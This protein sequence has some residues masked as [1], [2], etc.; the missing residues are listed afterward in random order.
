MTFLATLVLLLLAAVLVTPPVVRHVAEDWL[1]EQ[2]VENA[3]VSKVSFNLF[4]GAVE[5]DTVNI[6]GGDDRNGALDVLSLDIDMLA[7]LSKHVEVSGVTMRGGEFDI[8]SIVEGGVHIG[9]L[10]FP[11]ANVAAGEVQE[12]QGPSAW[13]FGVY[14][15][16]I[17]DVTIRILDQ[18]HEAVIDIR[19]L[20]VDRLQSF[21]P[22][23]KTSVDAD[24]RVDGARLQ[25]DG[26]L[27][28]LSERPAGEFDLRVDELSLATYASLIPVLDEPEGALSLDLKV[29][30]SI[31][32]DPSTRLGL[33]VEGTTALSGFRA[34][35]TTLLATVDEVAWDGG[36]T[37]SIPGAESDAPLMAVTGDV[38]ADAIQVSQDD[39]TLLDVDSARISGFDVAGA[40]KALLPSVVIRGVS[41]L[42]TETA[43]SSLS[44]GGV[45]ILDVEYTGGEGLAVDRVEVSDTSL[46]VRRDPDGRIAGLPTTRESAPEDPAF[47]VSDDGVSGFAASLDT[48]SFTGNTKV[49]F[50]DAAVEPAFALDTEIS[51]LELRS[52]STDPAAAPAAFELK[53]SGE[54]TTELSASGT[55]SLAPGGGQ[56]AIEAALSGF[57]LPRVSSYLPGYNIERGRLAVETVA[58][59]TD[60]ELTIENAVTLDRLKLSAESDD[61]PDLLGDALDMPLDLALDLLR[62]GDDRIKLD[63]PVTGR[64]DDLEVGTG[65]IL[66]LATQRAVQRAAVNYV[67]K[68]LQPLGTILF[69]SKVAGKASRPRFEPIIVLAGTG[70]ISGDAVDYADRIAEILDKRP[71]LSITFCG[72]ATTADRAA[73]EAEQAAS[74]PAEPGDVAA[75]APD[76]DALL[77]S[78]AEARGAALQTYLVTEKGIDAERLYR[79]RDTVES[80]GE[81]SPRIEVSL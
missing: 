64:L 34:G 71:R 3:E 7:L 22:E 19:E 53:L 68:S 49:S 43:G 58:S 66:R 41:L 10:Q 26:S 32:E 77:Q 18:R 31:D 60:G 48:L 44:V 42:G 51:Q 46:D 73:L 56:V 47:A 80:E 35:M 72:V 33:Q 70:E 1:R 21:S 38:E 39:R 15:V 78:L 11:L 81:G 20:N 74:V 23:A 14:D 5:I 61:G 13:S 9:G 67:T 29:S 40:D 6:A 57:E 27:S 12:T 62:D 17:R 24:L 25:L 65:D 63:I 28:P 59:L 55:A 36:V 79:C 2:G 50:E 4:T 16:R 8:H 37:L 30:V 45:Q 75:P 76:Y 69:V 52:L 54:Q